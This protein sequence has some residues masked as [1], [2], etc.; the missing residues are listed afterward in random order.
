[1]PQPAVLCH[2]SIHCGPLIKVAASHTQ[3]ARRLIAYIAG[4]GSYIVNIPP[5]AV[6]NELRRRGR[7]KLDVNTII[8]IFI[9]IILAMTATSYPIHIVLIDFHST[10]RAQL[11][12]LCLSRRRRRCRRWLV[13]PPELWPLGRRQ[14]GAALG[15]ASRTTRSR[16]HWLRVE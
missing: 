13:S 1:M 9:I 4:R 10:L 14:T 6:L 12:E 7:Y 8:I 15:P 3:R 16:R 11:R 5:D 2:L